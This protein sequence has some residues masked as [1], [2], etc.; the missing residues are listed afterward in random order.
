[1]KL[2]L[3]PRDLEAA[4]RTVLEDR[5]GKRLTDEEWE[6][7]KHD[8]LALFRLLKNSHSDTAPNTEK[9]QARAVLLLAIPDPSRSC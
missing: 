7:T 9:P 3:A 5:A 2:A 4:A 8:L 6:T 1:M